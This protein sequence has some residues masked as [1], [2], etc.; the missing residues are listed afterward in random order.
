MRNVGTIVECV[1]VFTSC[2]CSMDVVDG[3][4]MY[5]VVMC[6]EVVKEKERE[7]LMCEGVI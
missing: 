4:D 3:D 6:V 2:S 5:V 1:C 7:I